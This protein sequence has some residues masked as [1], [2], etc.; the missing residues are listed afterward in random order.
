MSKIQPPSQEVKL[1]AMKTIY[2]HNYRLIE[3]ADNKATAILTV[4][5]V[6]LTVI[7]A[8]VGLKGD[9][10]S[11]GNAIDIASIII[12]TL[13]LVSCLSSLIFSILTISPFQKTGIP[14][15]KH[16][17]YYINILDHK[18]TDEY[19]VELQNA[20]SD[21]SLIEKGFSDQIYSI[22]VVNKRKY[23]FVK[24]CVW[25]LLSS[26]VIVGIFLVLTFVS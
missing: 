6:M 8:F 22:S 10:F 24:W 25:T 9:F 26:F 13:Y 7:L 4:N 17:Y 18:D 19:N 15:P 23:K 12:L 16:V 21:F 14:K 1:E 5:G 3:L 11:V 20:L 2:D